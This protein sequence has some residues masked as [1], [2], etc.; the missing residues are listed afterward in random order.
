MTTHIKQKG[1][2]DCA[3]A[4]I[5]MACNVEYERVLAS[6]PPDVYFHGLYA[7]EVIHAIKK[8]SKREFGYV[9]VPNVSFIDYFKALHQYRTEILIVERSGEWDDITKIHYIYFVPHD[10]ESKQYRTMFDPIEIGP[11]TYE[12]YINQRED[13]K[14][15]GTIHERFPK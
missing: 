7:G 10:R 12:D 1:Y 4:C 2:A 8:I 5:A 14:V 15:I 11:M 9:E 3:V 13:W 6:V